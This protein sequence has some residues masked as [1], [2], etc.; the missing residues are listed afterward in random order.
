MEKI[1]MAEAIK[2]VLQDEKIIAV[3]TGKTVEECVAAWDVHDFYD[4][5]YIAS[6]QR[7]KDF[8]E[9]RGYQTIPLTDVSLCRYYFDGV[10]QIDM[11][12]R[13]LKGRGGAMTQEKLLF[14]HAQQRLAVAYPNKVKH[15]LDNQTCP[16]PIEVLPNA[17]SYVARNIIAKV[18]HATVTWRAGVLTDQGNYILDAYNLSL[19]EADE[20][21]RWLK[22]ITGIVEHGLFSLI[23]FDQ[24]YIADEGGCVIKSFSQN[25]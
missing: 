4:K 10:D 6:S 21:E 14:K 3:G 13:A 5:R 15:I 11:R 8:L 16:L 24:L 7:T 17:R 19:I 23:Q 20:V 22:S 12:G 1:S 25:Q 2:G 18:P 9:A